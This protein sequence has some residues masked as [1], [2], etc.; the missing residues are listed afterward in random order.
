MA[1]NLKNFQRF[2]KKKR[3]LPCNYLTNWQQFA[4]PN[5]SFPDRTES[6]KSVPQKAELGLFC[7]LYKL[8]IR[9]QPAAFM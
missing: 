4:Y 3:N 2:L 6:V 8:M 7:F 1:Y 9:R 5:I